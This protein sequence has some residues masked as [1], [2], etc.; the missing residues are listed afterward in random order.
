MEDDP[1]SYLPPERIRELEQ[2]GA[3]EQA[4]AIVRLVPNHERNLRPAI[5]MEYHQV[6]NPYDS[7]PD[8]DNCLWRA[9]PRATYYSWYVHWSTRHAGGSPLQL[10][11]QTLWYPVERSYFPTI[12][13]LPE[14]TVAQLVDLGLC[15]EMQRLLQQHPEAYYLNGRRPLLPGE[16]GPQNPAQRFTAWDAPIDLRAEAGREAER[17]LALQTNEDAAREELLVQQATLDRIVIYRRDPVMHTTSDDIPA[18]LPEAVPPRGG[19]PPPPPAPR[20]RDEVVELLGAA[21]TRHLPFNERTRPR[22]RFAART[23]APPPEPALPTGIREYIDEMMRAQRQMFLDAARLIVAERGRRRRR[24]HSERSSSDSS[25]QSRSRSR[26]RTLMEEAEELHEQADAATD[27]NRIRRLR[28][29]AERRR[30]EALVPGTA[31]HVPQPPPP[32]PPLATPAQT[33]A[34]TPGRTQEQRAS[35]KYKLS[36]LKSVARKAKNQSKDIITR[37]KDLVAGAVERER[38][39]DIFG[40][41]QTIHQRLVETQHRIENM[42]SYAN[43]TILMNETNTE[44][45]RE[46]QDD[47]YRQ[48]EAICPK[49]TAPLVVRH[50]DDDDDSIEALNFSPPPIEAP[51]PGGAASTPIVLTESPAPEPKRAATPVAPAAPA[52]AAPAPAAPAP[53]APAP[54]PE[55]KP[56]RT[57]TPAP[58]APAP[59]PVP[60]P[61]PKPVAKPVARRLLPLETASPITVD[62]DEEPEDKIAPIIKQI[63]MHKRH[64]QRVKRLPYDI[65]SDS[66]TL[67]KLKNLSESLDEYKANFQTVGYKE[68]LH[69]YAQGLMTEV[70][71]FVDEMY[72]AAGYPVAP[73]VEAGGARAPAPALP[74][75]QQLLENAIQELTERDINYVPTR[76]VQKTVEKERREKDKL[77]RDPFFE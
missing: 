16:R 49:R 59:K 76:V 32:P 2:L 57:T 74:T 10:P 36:L 63:D 60:E 27:I 50:D 53:A 8:S 26:S 23:P 51:T 70:R 13:Q 1:L 5:L 44:A 24:S 68:Q 11:L 61:A 4:R 48:L 72:R 43:A 41:L 75:D 54:V 65:V 19:T 15:S 14:A 12:A 18:P 69:M 47:L 37:A 42:S 40:Q 71:E 39:D 17:Q 6:P 46:Q 21:G 58:A 52:P 77:T 73:P 38:A 3:L 34:K 9:P 64:L 66:L 35:D 22:N 56:K 55:P 31:P 62:E 25:S 67:E 30:M 28:G 29:E 45:L 7:C 20:Q 33:R